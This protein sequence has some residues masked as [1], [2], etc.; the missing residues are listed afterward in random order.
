MRFSSLLRIKAS[1]FEGA[2]EIFRSK[3]LAYSIIEGNRTSN[4][5]GEHCFSSV[6]EARF[7]SIKYKPENK[8]RI[9]LNVHSMQLKM[10]K[11]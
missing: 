2:I 8:T 5:I 4:P 7:V 11:E 1:K 3:F 10:L 6:T 9:Y